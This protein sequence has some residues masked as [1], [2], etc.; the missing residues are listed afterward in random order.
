MWESAKK[1]EKLPRRF[2]PLVVAL[3]F[4]DS[5]GP[6]FTAVIARPKEPSESPNTV[7]AKERNRGKTP[8]AT[9]ARKKSLDS[10]FRE[11]EVFK[12]RAVCHHGGGARNQP[13]SLNSPIFVPRA[14]EPFSFLNGPSL[15]M[16]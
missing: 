5:G 8:N 2:C 4:F 15:R 1:C 13:N 14:S 6:K 7:V 11:D 12:G 16:P 3:W 9:I 10:L